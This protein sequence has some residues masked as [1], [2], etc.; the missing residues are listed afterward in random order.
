MKRAWCVVILAA[1]ASLLP[2]RAQAFEREWHT[3]G[4]IGITAYPHYY[5]VG[6]SLGLNAAYG[7][8]DVF[9]FK[10]ELLGGYH[11][12]SASSKSPTESALPWSAAAGLSYK[13]DVLQWIPYGALLVGWHP[14]SGGLGSRA[15]TSLSS[16]SSGRRPPSCQ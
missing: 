16:V 3:G 1:C 14:C 15:R 8:S 2:S 11:S 12:Y 6:P 9:D 4:G 5:R 10:L 13:L 7:I